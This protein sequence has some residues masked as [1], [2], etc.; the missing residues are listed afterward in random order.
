MKY[1][2]EAFKNGEAIREAADGALE[3]I[4]KRINDWESIDFGNEI[5][6]GESTKEPI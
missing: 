3:A 2:D 4:R 6:E 5:S 1:Y